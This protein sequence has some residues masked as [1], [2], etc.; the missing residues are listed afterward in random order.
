MASNKFENQLFRRKILE[1]VIRK[2]EEYEECC[3]KEEKENQQKCELK[4]GF[5]EMI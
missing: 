3:R 5:L 2:Y 4:S 1:S